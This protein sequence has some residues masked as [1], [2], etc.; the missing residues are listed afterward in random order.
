MLQPQANQARSLISL[1]GIWNFALASGVDIEAEEAWKKAIPPKVQIP[2]PASYNDILVDAKVKDHVGWVYY[3][4]QVTVPR[5]FAG[6]HYHLRFDAATHHARVYVDDHFAGDHTGG[7]TPFEVAIHHLVAAGREFRLTV[8][9]S[10]ELSWET[11]PPGRIQTGKNGQRKQVY[12]HDFFNYSGLARSVWLCGVPHTRIQDVV[13]V[14]DV[15]VDGESPQGIV[16]YEIETSTAL[17][18]GQILNINLLD[19]EGHCVSRACSDATGSISVASPHLWRPGAAYLYRL[20]VEIRQEDDEIVDTYSVNVGI[21]SVKIVG[22]QF[23]IN[24]KP[25]YFTGFGK[26]ED[27]PIR[28]KGHDPAYMVHDFELL[29][30]TNANSFRTAHYPYAEEV[31]D[32]ADRHGIVVI[33]ET[34][35]VGLNL[36]IVAGITGQKAPPTFSP[37]TVSVKTQATHKQAIR[38]LVRRDKNH[39]SV[40]MWCIANEPASAAEGAREYFE[41]LVRLTRELDPTRPIGFANE[42]Q[43]SVDQDLITDLFDVI[44]LNRYYGW[45][46]NTGDLEAAEA[47]MEDELR[48][49]QDKFG[50]P[51]I[52]SEYGADTLAGLHTVLDVPWSEEYQTRVLELSGRVLDKLDCVVGEHVWN[53]ADFQTPSSFIFRVDGNKKGVFTRDRRP[54]AAAAT[55]KKRWAEICERPAK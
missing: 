25:F 10:N 21:R 40:V 47:D 4:R 48:A 22:R 9:V 33:D 26:H 30:W 35:A 46:L 27:T 2:V 45:Y 55:L 8:A 17:G 18:A 43:A 32:Y 49:W 7:Y 51:M 19:E 15:M 12:Q 5:H 52:L 50:K 41:P 13:V 39:P 44:C 6:Q 34:A 37:D 54:K 20:V 24:D 53:F 36:A 16:T 3:Q 29:K 11:I 28:G 1:D 42:K 14:T 38:E 31:L 23:L